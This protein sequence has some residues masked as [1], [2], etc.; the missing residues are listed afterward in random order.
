MQLPNTFSAALSSLSIKP[1]ALPAQKFW[2]SKKIG[3]PNY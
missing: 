3:R 2:G 1:I